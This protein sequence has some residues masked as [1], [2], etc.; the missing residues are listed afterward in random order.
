MRPREGPFI[1]YLNSVYCKCKYSVLYK[2]ENVMWSIGPSQGKI[3][4]THP[5]PVTTILERNKSWWW[6]RF[7][8]ESRLL[9]LLRILILKE[10]ITFLGF[11]FFDLTAVFSWFCC[12][13]IIH[14]HPWS[15]KIWK[16]FSVIVEFWDRKKNLWDFIFIFRDSWIPILRLKSTRYLAY[17]AYTMPEILH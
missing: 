17:A 7:L 10:L 8:S 3:A 6:R 1:Q 5:S 9:E 2:R 11:G 13:L 16:R 15:K 4:S 12:L 14:F